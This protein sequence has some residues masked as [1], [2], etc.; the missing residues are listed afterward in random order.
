MV[1]FPDA[2][3]FILTHLRAA[4]LDCGVDFP[5]KIARPFV[6]VE[7]VGGYMKWPALETALLG[8][9]ALGP[10]RAAAHDALRTAEGVLMSLPPQNLGATRVY[11]V[12]GAHHARDEADTSLHRWTATYGVSLRPI[13]EETGS[14]DP[15]PD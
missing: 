10:D 11:V 7:R 12:M 3:A 1:K 5:E 6:A 4:G 9:R 14:A 15:R 8:I 13:R 2:E